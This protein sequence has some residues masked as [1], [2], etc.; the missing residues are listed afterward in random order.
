MYK[1]DA[2][3]YVASYDTIVWLEVKY[4]DVAPCLCVYVR[5][6]DSQLEPANTKNVD[7]VIPYRIGS[8][9]M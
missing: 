4:F 5:A 3:A 8:S 7:V 9:L 6:C 2:E 1:L